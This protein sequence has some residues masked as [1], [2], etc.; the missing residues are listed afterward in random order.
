MHALLRIATRALAVLLAGSTGIAHAALVS[1]ADDKA[2]FVAATSPTAVTL[3]LDL[4]L[5]NTKSA[6]SPVANLSFVSTTYVAGCSTNPCG[7]QVDNWIRGRSD[8][9]LAISGPEDFTLTLS[10]KVHAIAFDLVEPSF[11]TTGNVGDCNT[12]C[13]DT[14][15]SISFY[16]G[17]TLLGEFTYNAPDDD[18]TGLTAR[19]GFF[20]VT[21]DVAFN[22]MVVFDKRRTSDNEYFGAF[23][24][25]ANPPAEQAVPLPG[26]LPLAATALA[27]LAAAGRR[28][29]SR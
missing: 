10:K 6:S 13:F 28:R 16:D 11:N 9:F 22:K 26:T 18:G 14:E 24:L 20:G 27:L 3:P 8:N 5:D 15:F 23:L 25:S 7:T 2:G 29:P 1:Y 12:S 17:T 21:S 19:A 4:T